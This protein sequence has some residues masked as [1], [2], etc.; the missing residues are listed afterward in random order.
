MGDVLGN[1]ATPAGI[2]KLRNALFTSHC[3][4]LEDLR[5]S[6][7]QAGSAA[8]E[9]FEVVPLPRKRLN[10][11]HIDFSDNRIDL[12]DAGIVSVILRGCLEISHLVDLD[13]S[14]NHLD[15]VG[16]VRFIQ[17]GSIGNSNDQ[18]IEDAGKSFKSLS[19]APKIGK[20]IRCLPLLRS[21][22]ISSCELG[23][24]TAHMI[25]QMLGSGQLVGLEILLMSS[26][27]I[28]A[29]GVDSIVAG[30]R[31]LQPHCRLNELSLALNNI[32]TEGLLSLTAAV[33]AGTLNNIKVR[34]TVRFRSVR[35]HWNGH[36]EVNVL[37]CGQQ[38]LDVADCGN[39]FESVLRFGR[40]IAASEANLKNLRIL[41][42]FGKQFATRKMNLLAFSPKFM[43]KVTIL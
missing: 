42:V 19:Q 35:A 33:V 28:G 11:A 2:R 23:N 3:P 9:F 12:L 13:L 5:M 6:C 32:G 20:S 41:R 40:A 17:Q 39:V 18:P 15:D 7:N 14:C 1:N 24:T 22:N 43:E 38:V 31:S 26:N 29:V 16:F 4:N 27:N 8:I 10:I 36:E 34:E 25:G 21:L 37:R 30:M